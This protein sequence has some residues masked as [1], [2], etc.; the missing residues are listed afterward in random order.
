[1][2]ECPKCKASDCVGFNLKNRK[3]MCHSCL[4]EWDD[5]PMSNPDVSE[6]ALVSRMYNAANDGD[7]REKGQYASKA[8]L[9]IALR[10]VR[11]R[12]KA[13]GLREGLTRALEISRKHEQALDVEVA[14]FNELARADA[15][16]PRPISPSS[17][18]AP[19]SGPC[20]SSHP[21]ADPSDSA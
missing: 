10:S 11:D 6:E 2:S 12:L 17:P 19:E 20:T 1:M 21:P 15:L 14:I 4:H 3:L 16:S 9:R 7:I 5:T 13:E 8:M 18:S